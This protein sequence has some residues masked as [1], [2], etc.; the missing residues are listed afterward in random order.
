MLFLLLVLVLMLMSVLGL[1]GLLILV[2]IGSRS[3]VLGSRVLQHRHS[4]GEGGTEIG[5]LERKCE[6]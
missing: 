5:S 3:L 4:F 1:L 6:R 2:L